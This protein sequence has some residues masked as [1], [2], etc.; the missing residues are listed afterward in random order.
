M[1]EI[2]SRKLLKE[3]TP[4]LVQRRPSKTSRRTGHVVDILRESIDRLSRSNDLARTRNRGIPERRTGRSG[5]SWHAGSTRPWSGA[6][7]SSLRGTVRDADGVEERKKWKKIRARVWLNTRAVVIL[8]TL[9][10]GRVVKRSCAG[11]PGTEGCAQN[12]GHSSASRG[13]REIGRGRM[14]PVHHQ[15]ADV[16]ITAHLLHSTRHS[17]NDTRTRERTAVNPRRVSWYIYM[18]I[19]RSLPAFLPDRKII[20]RHSKFVKA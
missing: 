7:R 15:S 20:D 18:Y 12:T 14:M 10:R 11:P 2:E 1:R 8:F 13:I 5:S 16:Q 4:T 9:R 19:S 3:A 6:V 17:F